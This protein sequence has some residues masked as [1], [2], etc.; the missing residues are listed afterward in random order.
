MFRRL[1]GCAA[2]LAF[3]CF[4]VVVSAQNAADLRVTKSNDNTGPVGP[5]GGYNS[6]FTVN[7]L[8]P[9]NRPYGP[10]ATN[11]LVIVDTVNPNVSSVASSTPGFTCTGPSASQ[12]TCTSTG[13]GTLQAGANLSVTAAFTFTTNGPPAPVVTSNNACVGG[14]AGN[15]GTPP[16][17]NTANDCSGGVVG[18]VFTPIAA[19]VNTTKRVAKNT[20]PGFGGAGW[21]V[22]L[23]GANRLLATEND[24]YWR[25]SATPT[26][27]GVIPTL[28]LT[29]TINTLASSPLATPVTIAQSTTPGACSYSAPT[30]T[31]T[32]TNVPNGVEVGAVIRVSRAL[33]GGTFTN[34][35][36]AG[37]PDAV[38]SGILSA[39]A[40]I[41]IDPAVDQTINFA[42]PT[43]PATQVVFTVSGTGGTSGNPVV[44]TSLT[45]TTCSASGV[46]GTTITALAVGTCTIAGNQAGN[47]TYKAAPQVT[48]DVQIPPRVTVLRS[49]TG[50]GGAVGTQG[51]AISCGAGCSAFVASGVNV[52]LNVVADAFS[53]LVGL[54]GVSCPSVSTNGQCAFTMPATDVAVNL[55]FR[56]TANLDGANTPTEYN[57]A[58]D[59][60]ILLR[61]LLGYRGSALLTGIASQQ[62]AT[63]IE[64]Y[65]AARVTANDFDVDGDGKTLAS[66]DGLIILRRMLLRTEAN[67]AVITVGKNPTP[68]TPLTDAQIVTRIDRLFP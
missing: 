6:T 46:N 25:I 33:A 66:T 8:G 11:P 3:A 26:S 12:V 13:S 43:T 62:S 41:E 65:L 1:S 50:S 31:C 38:L 48:R 9:L 21:T 54:T 16:D 28:V 63:A 36:N 58:T 20:N 42:Q 40:Q 39:A 24:L 14:T 34:F 60:L 53:K 47:N 22:S 67:P 32:F 55:N 17:N 68:L 19:T 44:F 37:S 2:L 56:A 27:G 15:V 7:N 30:V 18:P 35:V 5:G 29:D 61:Y 4:S 64:T 52:N 45:P 59:G 23:I 49:G 57:A 10:G 51:A